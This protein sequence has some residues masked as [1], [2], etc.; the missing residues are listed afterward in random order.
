M[1]MMEVCLYMCVMV[2]V[3]SE[4]RGKT[5]ISLQ[6]TSCHKGLDAVSERPIMHLVS[7]KVRIIQQRA[8]TD[9]STDRA[10]RTTKRQQ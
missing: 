2:P 4:C 3:W 10:V 1:N 5:L 7:F 8:E 6:N 9:N